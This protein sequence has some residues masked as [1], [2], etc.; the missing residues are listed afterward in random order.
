[1]ASSSSARMIG[2]LQSG[3]G[4]G[5]GSCR[6]RASRGLLVWWVVARMEAVGVPVTLR[7]GLAADTSAV[8]GEG[9][10]RP[11]AV[12]RLPLPRAP[13]RAGPPERRVPACAGAV[14]SE[15]G[16]CRAV[17]AV[18]LLALATLGEAWVGAGRLGVGLSL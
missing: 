2:L 7:A 11:A 17:A 10:L 6:P 8:A 3:T 12:T 16:V 18:A 15:G 14:A 9:A 4:S 13:R 5:R 1:M